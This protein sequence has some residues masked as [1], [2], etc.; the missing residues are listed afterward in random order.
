MDTKTITVGQSFNPDCVSND[1]DKIMAIY[2]HF[3]SFPKNREIGYDVATAIGL[4]FNNSYNKDDYAN[5]PFASVSK[6]LLYKLHTDGELIAYH[7]GI[8]N[9]LALPLSIAIKHGI[10][11]VDENPNVDENTY[12]VRSYGRRISMRTMLYHYDRVGIVWDSNGVVC[13][14]THNTGITC[15]TSVHC[16]VQV[17][18]IPD[19]VAVKS[20]SKNA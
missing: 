18:I 8:Y 1:T 2:D 3:Y 15:T 4:E 13:K 11:F 7:N 14:N 20:A 16:P 9:D 10:V 12:M 17:H 6:T 5:L 19:M